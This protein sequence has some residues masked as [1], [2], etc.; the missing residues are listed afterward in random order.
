[1]SRNGQCIFSLFLNLINNV[2]FDAEANFDI[3]V[4]RVREISFQKY[5]IHLF[6]WYIKNLGDEI[7]CY[8][9]I[10]ILILRV[11][12]LTSLFSNSIGELGYPWKGHR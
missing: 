6:Q 9:H 1:M 12:Q 4:K 10:L 8:M 2:R 7:K 11:I 3:L 5:S